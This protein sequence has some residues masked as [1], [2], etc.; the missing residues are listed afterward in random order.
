MGVSAVGK[1]SVAADLAARLGVSAA[2]ADDLHPPS[3]VAKM[4]AGV[5]LDDDDRAPWLAL[6]GAALS[7]REG[8][9][10][11]A[12]SALKRSYRDRLRAACPDVVFVHLSGARGL[13]AD[14][15]ARRTNHFMPPSL[16][17]SQLR[18]LEPLE[19][20]EP[21]V[22][23]D[24]SASVDELVTAAARWVRAARES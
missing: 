8:G 16:L 19:D 4:A 13:L 15:A 12:C 17:D 14:R 18:T 22:V 1:S 11:M 9:L 20:D 24:V 23:L 6:V 21:G 2:D 5:S 7:A 3:N 10:V